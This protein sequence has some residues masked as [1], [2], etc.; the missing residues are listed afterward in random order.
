VSQPDPRLTLIYGLGRS[1]LGVA[2][3]LARLGWPAEW[4]DARPK[5]ADA[6]QAAALGAAPAGETVKEGR[7][8]LV[9]A[10]PGVPIDHPD[11]L[12]LAATGAEVIGEAELCYRTVDTPL[13]G[14][15]GTAGKGT[16]TTWIAHLL[17]SQGLDAR[18]GGNTGTPLVDVAGGADVA[19]VELSSFQ[20]E[21]VKRLHLRVA[22]VTNLD[23]DHIDRHGTVAAYHAAKA[24]IF[25]N[26]GAGDAA[27]LPE[28][29]SL[30][31]PEGV[32]AYRVPES[33]LL[34]GAVT[35]L[36]GR[37]YLPA[38]ELP[39]NQ[40]PQNA[41]SA[42][43][44]TL[45][46]FEAMGL[47]P[48]NEA[49]RAALR[50]YQGLPGRFETVAVIDGTRFIEDSIATRTLAVKAALE[51]APAPVAWIVGGIDKGADLAALKP[52]VEAKVALILAIGRDGKTIA[53]RFT[54][55]PCRAIDESEGRAALAL[56]CSEGLEAARGGSV[57]LAPIG[58]S[59]DQFRDYRE[60]GEAFT[61]AARGLAQ[62]LGG[63][64]R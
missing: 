11:L 63:E 42:L 20:L 50:D 39:S 13:I 18:A 3:H 38:H 8:D 36:E 46:Y 4:F 17:R 10:A 29:V 32:A 45:A 41:A 53:S 23:V 62:R 22:V 54:G 44:A 56:A 60:R 16:T 49:V 9:V 24:N 21:R 27:V 61:A 12:R 33:G 6:A 30:G 15:T 48:D 14:V 31:L 47:Q 5:E 59:F 34:N 43:K 2:R 37:A 52:V 57:L 55:T 7:Y 64:A 58:T 51:A 40:H 26:M 28:S 19:V 35:D 25:A 1:G